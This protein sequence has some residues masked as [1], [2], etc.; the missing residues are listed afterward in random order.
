MNLPRYI[1]WS[2]RRSD[3]CFRAVVTGATATEARDALHQYAKAEAELAVLCVTERA[4]FDG[5]P[6][7]RVPNAV[8]RVFQYGR[9]GPAQPLAWAVGEAMQSEAARRGLSVGEVDH[10]TR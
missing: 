1:G 6:P 8:A 2:R 7:D 5:P 4:S 3:R 9:V 10:A